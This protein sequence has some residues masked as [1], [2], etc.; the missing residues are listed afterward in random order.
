MKGGLSHLLIRMFAGAVTAALALAPLVL[1]GAVHGSQQCHIFAGQ[2]LGVGQI[3]VH[4]VLAPQNCCKCLTWT[5]RIGLDLS[6]RVDAVDIYATGRHQSR[7]Y[8]SRPLAEK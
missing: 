1:G 3:S 5:Q 8:T 7:F 4:A 2:T 6:L